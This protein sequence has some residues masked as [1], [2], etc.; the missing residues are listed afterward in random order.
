MDEGFELVALGRAL[1]HDPSFV[2][3]LVRGDV[4]RSG[5]THCNQCIAEMDRDGVR[6]VLPDAPGYRAVAGASP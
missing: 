5:C 2:T 1:L 6:C 3:R 4:E